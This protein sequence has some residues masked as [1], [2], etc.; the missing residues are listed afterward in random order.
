MTNTEIKRFIKTCRVTYYGGIVEVIG[1]YGKTARFD[2]DS[3]ECTY[4]NFVANHAAI[5]AMRKLAEKVLHD[6]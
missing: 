2:Y 4:S 3:M 5:D 1:A 6:D